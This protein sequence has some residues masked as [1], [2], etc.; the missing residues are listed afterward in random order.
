VG[1]GKRDSLFQE[2]KEK[3]CYDSQASTA[4]PCDTSR[5][6]MKTVE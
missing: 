3:H 5:V 6:K 2:E 1:E 4:Y